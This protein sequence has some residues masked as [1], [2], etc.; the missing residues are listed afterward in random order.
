M[1]KPFFQKTISSLG[2]KFKKLTG[3]EKAV[4][5][6]ESLYADTTD[7]DF[8]EDT[9]P[10]PKPTKFGE[11]LSIDMAAPAKDESAAAPAKRA[12]AETEA[13]ADAADDREEGPDA[14]EKIL[15]FN[16]ETGNYLV[17]HYRK[18]F[19]ARLIQAN[20]EIKAY[21]SELKNRLLSYEGTKSRLSWTS[22]NFHNGRKQ[23]AKINVKTGLLV[24][25]LALDPRAL[26]GSVYRGKDVSDK[27][28][29]GDTPFEYKI[30]TPRKLKWGLELIDKVSENL[31]LTLNVI[32]PIDYARQ[33][34]YESTEELVNR[35]L[36]K[37]SITEESPADISPELLRRGEEPAKREAPSAPPKA[38]KAEPTPEPKTAPQEKPIEAK[39]TPSAITFTEDG[40]FLLPDPE[41]IA[42]V[43]IDE[44][45]PNFRPNEVVNL[46]ALKAKGFA[47]ESAEWL[48]VVSAS[49]EPLPKPIKVEAE[50]FSMKALQAIC[51]GDGDVVLL[52]WRKK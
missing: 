12:P 8:P 6:T 9:P 29:Y 14:C 21:Y 5:E 7:K 50:R 16:E 17:A 19:E 46:A 23:V 31:G 37:E 18:G 45:E 25:Y 22:D 49:G 2:D 26:E 43:N 27:K 44:V 20:P 35:G 30:R 28:K 48:R 42:V 47:D 32:E 40:E 15:A 13:D 39:K 4:D 11:Q 52:Q 38:E 3:K 51:T 41:K 10:E 36:I 24:L 33:Y 34:A 1:A